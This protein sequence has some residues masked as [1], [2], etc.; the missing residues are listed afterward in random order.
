MED[1]GG[2]LILGDAKDGGA[3]IRA[4]FARDAGS[5]GVKQGKPT[6]KEEPVTHGS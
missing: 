2:S 4:E 6:A 3:L 5:V 1:H